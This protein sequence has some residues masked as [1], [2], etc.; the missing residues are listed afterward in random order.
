MGCSQYND[1]MMAALQADLV[2]YYW[3]LDGLMILYYTWT[4]WTLDIGHGHMDH[5]HQGGEGAKGVC[6]CDE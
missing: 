1:G 2:R 5:G 6:V 3:L 4:H